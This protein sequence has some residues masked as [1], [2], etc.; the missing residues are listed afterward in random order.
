MSVRYA[1]RGVRLVPEYVCNRLYME[2]GSLVCQTICGA[3]VDAAVG[4]L[5]VETMSA[6]VVDVSLAVQEEIQTQMEEADQL[7][8]Q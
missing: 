6:M 3:G 4:R 1:R 5:V 8:R 2:D 7:R